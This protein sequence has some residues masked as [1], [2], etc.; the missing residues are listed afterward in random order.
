MRIN[1]I[2]KF[3]EIDN[4]LDFLDLW[5]KYKSNGEL[6]DE[7]QDYYV[8]LYKFL[9]SCSFKNITTYKID[10]YLS[11]F[12]EIPLSVDISISNLIHTIN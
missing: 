12:D 7:E 2:G 6:N 3:L 1:K 5:E 4:S 8:I 9:A 10:E 11:K